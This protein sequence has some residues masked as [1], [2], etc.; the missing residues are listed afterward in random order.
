MYMMNL[1]FEN[2]T[3]EEEFSK[4]C[5]SH[6][7]MVIN[8]LIKD[9]QKVMVKKIYF[10]G[11]KLNVTLI[12]DHE[13]LEIASDYKETKTYAKFSNKDYS[14]VYDNHPQKKFDIKEYCYQKGN[15]VLI[16]KN[17][18]NLNKE[19]NEKKYSYILYINNHSYNINILDEH[20]TFNED[21]F[22]RY[23]L[24]IYLLDINNINEMYL[25]ICNSND[26]SSIVLEINNNNN[27]ILLSKQG[28]L[29]KYHITIIND[30]VK[31]EVFLDNNK[32]YKKETTTKELAD[33]KVY[34]KKIGGRYG[35][36]K[37]N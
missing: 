10:E 29:L 17:T 16:K 4:L 5:D 22:L 30:D 3:V 13:K 18:I 1:L 33:D 14:I 8:D 12:V 20:K 24:D 35:T 7:L 36:R 27:D 26:I 32:F 37:E 9:Y 11:F 2:K 31:E 15:K 28:T 19:S 21:D 6:L 25:L 34:I 23:V